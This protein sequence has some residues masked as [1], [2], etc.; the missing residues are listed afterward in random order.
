MKRF[1]FDSPYQ[2]KGEKKILIIGAD[3]IELVPELDHS[4]S[5]IDWL[6]KY[7]GRY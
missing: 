6:I 2:K 4:Q 3:N 7:C 1:S 5:S